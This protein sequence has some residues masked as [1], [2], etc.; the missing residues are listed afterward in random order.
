MGSERSI[1]TC[2]LLLRA[3]EL[4]A[5][6]PSC[7]VAAL[8]FRHSARAGCPPSDQV[9]EPRRPPVLRGKAGM[10][11]PFGQG[12]PTLAVRVAGD[13]VAVQVGDA[14]AERLHA[15]EGGERQERDEE[16]VLDHGLPFLAAGEPQGALQAL[17]NRDHGHRSSCCRPHRLTGLIT[18]E[19]G[20]LTASSAATPEGPAPTSAF[21]HGDGERNERRTALA[22]RETA[23]GRETTRGPLGPRA[24]QGSPLVHCA[25]R[26][27]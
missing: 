18:H 7:R 14:V 24:R 20:W 5:A 3:D 22:W 19:A 15:D 2:V 13:D 10:S 25:T 12:A 4:V 6:P 27:G 9:I 17:H 1:S 8:R 11:R 23:E 16:G 26:A 21:R